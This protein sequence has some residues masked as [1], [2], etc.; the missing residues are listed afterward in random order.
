[1]PRITFDHH[2][3]TVR[4]NESVLDA[5]TRHGVAVP[6]SC[7]SGVCQTCMMRATRGTPPAEAQKGIKESLRVR[8]YFLACA[9]KP[10][11][12][13][14]AALPSDDDV[15]QSSAIVVG[16]TPLNDNIIR[17][18]LLCPA[19]FTY[20]AGQFVNVHH[21]DWVRS[22][23]LASVPGQ[24]D[25]LELH[26]QRVS[27]GRMSGWLHDACIVGD[28]VHLQGPLGDC[29]Y[30]AERQDQPLLLIGTGS[31]LAPLW[32][33]ARDALRQGHR[34]PIHLF[35]GG[36]QADDLYL[37]H[38][39]RALA[40]V[41]PQFSYTPCISRGEVGE[42]YAAGRANEVALQR[43]PHLKGW[44][45][46]LCG[47]AAMVKTVKKRAFLAGA[48]LS[49]IHADPFEFSEVPA[50]PVVPVAQAQTV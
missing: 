34:G 20:R 44:R 15:P 9:C 35:H 27:N 38:E 6:S 10:T 8:N 18:R 25:F 28:P 21:G 48:A 11:E 49:D 16:K 13:M 43:H 19:P 41:Y 17:L 22:Y 46:F 12:D 39:L 7:R 5:L 36:R 23:S 47:N 1:M 31:G 2:S 37:T 30:T 29:Y 32:G 40:A 4:E 14:E 42:G 26:V 45:V 3:Y 33:I 50:V 24:D